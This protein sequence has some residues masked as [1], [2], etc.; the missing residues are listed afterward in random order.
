MSKSLFL[1]LMVLAA[2]V[3][4]CKDSGRS[5]A[6][7][8]VPMA[9]VNE[10]L[11]K[12]AKDPYVDLGKYTTFGI[13]S[14]A[15]IPDAKPAFGDQ[16]LEKQVGFMVRCALEARGY[17]MAASSETPDFA[18]CLFG[19]NAYHTSYIAP[20]S[21]TLPTYV[22]G[23]TMNSNIRTNGNVWGSGGQYAS[24]SGTSTVATTTSGHW[25]TNTYTRPGREVGNYFPYIGVSFLDLKTRQWVWNGNA[26]GVSNN[27]DVR[28]SC[29]IPL[30]RLAEKMP[31]CETAATDSSL[32]A[33][34]TGLTVGVC[35][36][37]GDNAFPM[38]LTLDRASPALRAGIKAYD[39]IVAIDGVPCSDRPWVE[40]T[41][42]LAGV[43]GS[44]C[45]LNVV[46]G[47]KQFD[48]AFNRITQ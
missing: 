45:R 46:R 18:V 20:R 22:P 21:V 35:T 40:V 8:L 43:N 3:V 14:S 1:C 38:V 47:K 2:G 33:T 17:R 39:V 29:Q 36:L 16:L 30:L 48:V 26:V 13:M 27:P 11:V 32:A 7:N 10:P 12:T 28:V 19:D 23:Q 42:L 4:G 9:Q 24:Y 44:E 6:E 37:D 25:S 15:A 41:K 31:M 5:V 34:R